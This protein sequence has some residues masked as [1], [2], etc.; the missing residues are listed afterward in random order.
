MFILFSEMYMEEDG[1]LASI[2]FIFSRA[3]V[4]FFSFCR[5]RV[6]TRAVSFHYINISYRISRRS[7]RFLL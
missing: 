1:T 6:Y 5:Q 2:F 3:F 4:I 7:A